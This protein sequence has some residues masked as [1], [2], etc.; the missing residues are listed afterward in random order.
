MTAHA[1]PPPAVMLLIC[2]GGLYGSFISWLVLQERINTQ[3]YDTTALGPVLFKAPLVVNCCQALFASVVGLVYSI[4]SDGYLPVNVFSQN[5]PALARSYVKSFTLI[6]IT[7]SISTPIGYQSLK[8]VDYLAFLLAK[9]CKLIPV[10]LVHTVLYRTRFP[11]YKYVVAGA[12]TVGVAV[13]TLANTSAKKA[14]HDGNT[15]V[16]MGQLFASM[17]LDGLTNSTQDHMF[18]TQRAQSGTVVKITGA[19]LMCILNTFVFTLTLGYAVLFRL[20]ELTYTRDFVT[21][22]P[23]ALSNI[24]LF[25]ALGLMGQVFVFMILERFDLLVLVTAT[26][27]RKMLSMVVSVV[28][29]GHHLVPLQWAGIACVFGGIGYE[30]AL[31]FRTREPKKKVE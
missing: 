8:H 9:S 20:D 21:R 26:V 25:A 24:V 11:V 1:G 29:F 17:I 5:P 12:V 6:A 15:L 14:S 30:A 4:V 13:F 19:N 27:T 22:Y 28:M 31:K 2:V 10:M 23:Q 18:K 7:S 3:P 16:G